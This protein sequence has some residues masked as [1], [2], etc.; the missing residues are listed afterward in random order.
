MR[1]LLF[2]AD[3]FRKWSSKRR[4]LANQGRLGVVGTLEQELLHRILAGR[5]YN[6]DC[7]Y[8]PIGDVV[9]PR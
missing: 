8:V 2:V 6:R 7:Q 9:N 4:K 5:P 1:K 3:P